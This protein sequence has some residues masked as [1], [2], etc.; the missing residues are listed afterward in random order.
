MP[1]PPPIES[2]IPVTWTGDGD[3]PPIVPG[4]GDAV[5][6]PILPTSPSERLLISLGRYPINSNPTNIEWKYLS[7]VQ[8]LKYTINRSG[9]F[10]E[11]SAI[12][13]GVNI[14]NGDTLFVRRG[15]TVLYA[16]EIVNLDVFEG[17]VYEVSGSCG[18][19]LYKNLPALEAIMPTQLAIYTL[20]WKLR[21]LYSTNYLS[22]NNTVGSIDP[23][24]LISGL[25]EGNIF[26]I[27][28][29]LEGKM[30]TPIW[31]GIT[32]NSS[33]QYVLNFS[34]LGTAVNISLAASNYKI[35]SETTEIPARIIFLSSSPRHPQ[36]LP[37][38]HFA[39]GGFTGDKDFTEID[40]DSTDAELVLGIPKNAVGGAEN[41]ARGANFALS[42][43]ASRKSVGADSNTVVAYEGN[44]VYELD[45]LTENINY[46]PNPTP[47]APKAGIS[48]IVSLYAKAEV[49]AN[50]SNLPQISI[51]VSWFNSGGGTI[52]T[53]N[54]NRTAAGKFWSLMETG[55]M[56]CPVGA[57]RYRILISVVG[58]TLSTN[59]GGIHLDKIR[60][61][62]Q[63]NFYPDSWQLLPK[64]SARITDYSFQDYNS[65]R[66]PFEGYSFCEVKA[67]IPG[68]SSNY[69]SLTAMIPIP[70]QPG[71]RYTWAVW[72]IGKPSETFPDFRMRFRYYRANG[73][74]LTEQVS[75]TIMAV[76]PTS[77]ARVS[78]NIEVPI[79]AANVAVSFDQLT[80]GAY[81]LGAI[82][83][84][85]AEET[86]T[87][88]YGETMKIYRNAQDLL[89]VSPYTTLISEY[90][91]REVIVSA[92]TIGTVADA[93]TYLKAWLTSKL[94]FKDSPRLEGKEVTGM[95]PL[96]TAPC[97]I[98]ER[99]LSYPVERVSWTFEG[100]V[101]MFTA[102]LNKKDKSN[103]EVLLGIQDNST[104]LLPA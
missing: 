48:Y 78:D 3:I 18:V 26:D 53:V 6:L 40:R 96:V 90:G 71:R 11:F 47:F 8:D 22:M 97:Y 99:Q 65:N 89:A 88:Y 98:T 7:G 9:G 52:Y 93:E 5:V 75:A 72:L 69:V 10:G 55:T 70:V 39:L 30:S 58:G 45:S 33:L 34:E 35:S 81:V 61:R 79:D 73:T 95:T 24:L 20:F 82:S 68:G 77:Y 17:G 27:F 13:E 49:S 104:K 91:D 19:L 83:L 57:V 14:E 76:S 23:A 59:N 74:F 41:G 15:N 80:S 62:R 28:V 66:V 100:D 32:M 1:L 92:D 63:Y 101:L 36:L 12:L 25:P 46:T 60:L 31:W 16:G 86:A 54:W 102:E 64:G 87:D 56:V 103:E 29:A 94:L 84:R 51:T 37:N 38:T 44:V 67:S 43:G 85:S 4:M 2:E 21:D 42:L 50:N